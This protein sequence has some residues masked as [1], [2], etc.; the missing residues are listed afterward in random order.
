MK[1]FALLSLAACSALAQA[2]A[3]TNTVRFMSVNYTGANALSNAVFRANATGRGTIYMGPGTFAI[4]NTAFNFGPNISLIG[5]GTN[6]SFITTTNRVE[7]DG[8]PL[9]PGDNSV[10]QDFTIINT[11]T[12]GVT[13]TFGRVA[14][15]ASCTNVLI[16]RVVMEA[17]TDCIY[18]DAGPFIEGVLDYSQIWTVSNSVFRTR[19]DNVFVSCDASDAAPARYSFFNCDFIAKGRALFPTAWNGIGEVT[20]FR[21]V[22]TNTF[23]EVHGGRIASQGAS[24]LVTAAIIS[25]G[26]LLLDSVRV[27]LG[28]NNL[29]R[30]PSLGAYSVYMTNTASRMRFENMSGPVTNTVTGQGTFYVN[31]TPNAPV[32]LILFNDI[33]P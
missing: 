2:I 28:T 27:M 3:P 4:N 18:T 33:W 13:G 7:T 26:R 10:W 14:D 17:D 24:N 21:I 22:G 15:D 12:N 11:A 23:V 20:N 19:Y 25:Q 31:T 29:A 5:S 9:Q 32:N 30:N 1:T 6:L 8:V 16:N